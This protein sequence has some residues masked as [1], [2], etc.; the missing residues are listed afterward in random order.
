MCFSAAKTGTAQRTGFI[1]TEEE[2][3]YLKSNLHL[4]AP[5]LTYA[6]VQA[7][8]QRL[9]EKYPD[10]Y[11]SETTAQRRA[12]INLS[13]NNIT[14]DAIDAYKEKYDSFAWTV[15][16][17]PADDPQIA[18][19][20]MLVQGKTSSNAAPIAREIIGKY[21]EDKGWEK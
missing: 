17:A 19:A 16:L 2:S 21:G 8:S 12:V 6:Q 13:K 20:V 4:I 1:S 14:Y 10:F 5:D 15:A 18:V 11:T 9:Q 3:S 7:E